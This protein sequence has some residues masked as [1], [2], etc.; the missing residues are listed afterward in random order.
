MNNGNLS[1]LAIKRE[2]SNF[3]FPIPE[4]D[5]KYLGIEDGVI[6]ARLKIAEAKKLITSKEIYHI[7][8]VLTIMN[9]NEKTLSGERNSKK[10]ANRYYFTIKLFSNLRKDYPELKSLL[11]FW[12]KHYYYNV[13]LNYL[14]NNIKDLIYKIVDKLK[15]I[16]NKKELKIFKEKKKE[17]YQKIKI[18][19]NFF[20]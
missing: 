19:R 5:K 8:E 3:L 12:K 15:E 10:M 4:E 13:V 20:D 9:S 7:S 16:K 1:C 14:P 18:Y 17:E 6:T 11:F 2:V